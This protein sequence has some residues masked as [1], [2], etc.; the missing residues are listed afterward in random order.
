MAP[1]EL[2][3]RQ[4]YDIVLLV[5]TGLSWFGVSGTC[6]INRPDLADQACCPEPRLLG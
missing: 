3:R 6:G 2:V 4:S 5:C 1:L